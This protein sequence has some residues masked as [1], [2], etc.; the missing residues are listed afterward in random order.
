MTT[1]QEVMSREEFK[2]ELKIMQLQDQ[3]EKTTLHTLTPLVS[4]WR[5]FLGS[6][7]SER[8]LGVIKD[9]EL[10]VRVRARHCWGECTEVSFDRDF[11]TVTV[12]HPDGRLI[13]L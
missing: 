13:E 4:Q 5:A 2:Q 10:T 3:K 9:L 1:M 8:F 6:Q 12:S 11:H 7:N